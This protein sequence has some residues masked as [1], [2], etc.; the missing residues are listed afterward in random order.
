MGAASQHEDRTPDVQ[1]QRSVPFR[2]DSSYN[3]HQYP[4]NGQPQAVH[5]LCRRFGRRNTETI[6]LMSALLMSIGFLGVLFSV[7]DSVMAFTSEQA[8]YAQSLRADASEHV[9][10]YEVTEP[11]RVHRVLVVAYVR[12]GSSFFGDVLS[13]DPRTFYHYEPLHQYQLSL[14]LWGTNSS[15]AME[16]VGNLFRCRFGNE[17]QYVQHAKEIGFGFNFNRL[18]WSACQGVPSVCFDSEFVSQLCSKAPIQVMKLAHMSLRQAHQWMISN[19][20]TARGMKL[21][22]LVRDPRGIWASRRNLDWCMANIGC[23]SYELL[24]QQMREDLNAF[25]DVK[26]DF[27]DSFIRVR[28]EDM[29]L[30]PFGEAKIVFRHTGLNFSSHTRGFLAT[31]TRETNSSV[32]ADKYSTKRDSKRAVFGWT[33]KLGYHEVVAVQSWCADVISRLQ[34]KI[35]SSEEE[36]KSGTFSPILSRLKVS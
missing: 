1:I 13:S 9:Q 21:V 4:D 29:A 23:H 10:T 18:L 31:H 24:C 6:F 2:G 14:R 19:P 5:R 8:R 20:E 16:T 15:R 17:L 27:P 33:R 26:R 22:H 35:V 32:L 12:S 7:Q 28:Y 30:N 3:G 36:L 11:S 34:Y 25:D